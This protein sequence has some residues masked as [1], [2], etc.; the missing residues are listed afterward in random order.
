MTPIFI[1]YRRDD[2]AGDARLLYERL[3]DRFGA[4]EVFFDVETIGGGI[5]WLKETR[6]RGAR[7]GVF[8]ALI[9]PHWLSILKD[10]Q[11]GRIEADGAPRE[12]LVRQE[13][14]WALRDWPGVVIPV[15][16]DTNMP[17]RTALPP[18]IRALTLYNCRQLRHTSFDRDASAVIADIEAIAEDAVPDDGAQGGTV[19]GVEGGGSPVEGRGPLTVELTVDGPAVS[20][21]GSTSPEGLPSGVTAP[22]DDHYQAVARQ[23]VQGTVVPILG[24]HV[25]GAMP[26]ASELAAFIANELDLPDRVSHSDLA[27]VAQY[28]A[29]T[30][31][32]S[33]LRRAIQKAIRERQPNRVHQFLATLPKRLEAFGLEPAFQLVMTSNYDDVLET[34]FANEHE[35]FD[36]AVYNAQTGQFVHYPWD[37]DA[38]APGIDV[39]TPNTY[40]GFPINLDEGNLERTVIV[41]IHG[42]TDGSLEPAAG[43]DG[44]VLTE[45]QYIDYLP[46]GDI[47]S[48][49]PVQI[50]N[51][52]RD[53]H[54]LFLGWRMRNWNERIFLRRL[55][56]TYPLKEKSWA[57]EGAPD[58]YERDGW[59]MYPGVQLFGTSPPDYVDRLVTQLDN[60]RL[61][62]A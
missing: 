11:A 49:V 30:E 22:G 57:I 62:R 23:L 50:L 53:S 18:S 28:V 12:D 3:V 26:D 36:L 48:V 6:A 43:G 7:G 25:C 9:G 54:N 46:K 19:G 44:Y 29:V 16:V 56:R 8:L 14:E 40:G 5:E 31:G 1:S 45:D 20:M 38:D 59:G 52:L 37:R 27:E 33:Q 13:I 2:V 10:R 39:A 17:D 51:K 47:R 60:Q 24:S 21:A 32:D 15:T 61:A 34:A 4:E 55:W 41:K 42:G 58:A 35:P